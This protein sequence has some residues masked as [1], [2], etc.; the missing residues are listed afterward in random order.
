M[1]YP[2]SSVPRTGTKNLD[3]SVLIGII[4]NKDTLRSTQSGEILEVH[5]GNSG[6]AYVHPL[7][8]ILEIINPI[9]PKMQM[10]AQQTK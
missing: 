4:H 7:E 5:R 10:E 9:S 3:R 8:Y 6:L 2:A 1:S